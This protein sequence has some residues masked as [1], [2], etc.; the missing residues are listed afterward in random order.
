MP[1]VLATDFFLPKRPDQQ[2]IQSFDS[3]SVKEKANIL[4]QYPNSF[5][6]VLSAGDDTS[7]PPKRN[8]AIRKQWAA[9]LHSKVYK[10][11]KNP[12]ILFYEIHSSEAVFSGFLC[13]IAMESFFNYEITKHENILPS[14][15]SLMTD[16]LNTVEIQAEPILIVH[17][18]VSEII[19]LEHEIPQTTPE[20]VSFSY[21][22]E[23]HRLWMLNKQQEEQLKHVAARVD[24]FHLAD[25]HHRS[26]CV[27]AL[28]CAKAT[29][30]P[31]GVFS[32]LIAKKRL[33]NKSFYWYLKQLPKTCSAEWIE[34]KINV[35][36]GIRITQVEPTTKNFPLQIALYDKIYALPDT[37]IRT[38]SIPDFIIQSFFTEINEKIKFDYFPQKN[39]NTFEQLKKQTNFAMAFNMLPMEVEQLFAL[40]L[41]KQKLPP[42]STLIFPKILTG[43]VI[44]GW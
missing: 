43:F 42:K 24:Y 5:L 11:I 33:I 10:A 15:V 9:F 27:Q 21:K 25:G 31:T 19:Q 37:S 1:K 23:T 14:R 6:S 22:N 12:G 3:I 29:K 44:A 38:L 36:K 30:K 2:V 26:A 7:N 41:K 8:S 39:T 32:F 35:S 4:N 20:L 13:S 28:Y 16:Y 34:K 17:E 40:A 18:D